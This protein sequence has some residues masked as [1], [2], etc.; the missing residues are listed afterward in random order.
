VARGV[1]CGVEEACRST[2]VEVLAGARSANHGAQVAAPWS[3]K[4]M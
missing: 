1:E 3:S 4:C 2:N